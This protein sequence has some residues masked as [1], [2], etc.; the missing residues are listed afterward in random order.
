MGDTDFAP[1]GTLPIGTL[2]RKLRLA[3]AITG[4]NGDGRGS[5]LPTASTD[6][7]SIL[8]LQAKTDKALSA[9]RE[10]ARSGF[11]KHIKFSI[12]TKPVFRLRL[13]PF[14]DSNHALGGGGLSGM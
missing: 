13:R 1:R 12:I 11:S 6:P 3:H 7:V 2:F 4:L 8:N 14:R 5:R 9:D 10:D